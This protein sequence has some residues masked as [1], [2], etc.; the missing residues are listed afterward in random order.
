MTPNRRTVL[1][2]LAS[3]AA[4]AGCISDSPDE[5]STDDDDDTPDENG[6]DGS[7]EDGEAN[8]NPD[9]PPK[10][11]FPDKRFPEGCPSYEGV[12]RVV[13][14]DAVTPD[15]VPVVLE[16]STRTVTEGHSIGFT[17]S[18]KTDGEL[19]TNLYNWRLSK[20]VD[21]EWFWVAPRGHNQPLMIIEPGGSHEWTVTV[22][23]EGIEDGEP[24]EGASGTSD[25]T[26]SGLGGGHYA[27]R[28]RGWLADESYEEAMAFAAIFE[29]D[30]EPI[31]LTTTTAI[32][33]TEWDGETLVARSERRDPDSEHTTLGAYELERL[34]SHE[35]NSPKL[36]TEQLLRNPQRR[37]AVALAEQYDADRVRLEEYNA[38]VPIF[39]RQS[40]GVFAYQGTHYEVSTREIGEG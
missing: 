33:E 29:F 27:F 7:G 4:L 9:D 15:E 11:Q 2:T 34:D 8:S 30:E 21:G 25:L 39:G 5:T 22:D 3:G 40:D 24:V 6:G 35:G 36:I 10:S 38:T 1:A 32:E 18:N 12:E 19:Q 23:N 16:P 26:V 14:Y 20:Q 17:L 28:A 31:T 37:D 13:C